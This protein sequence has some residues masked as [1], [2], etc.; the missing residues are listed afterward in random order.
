M[1]TKLL[2]LFVFVY[3]YSYT[4]SYIP[5]LEEDHTWSVD[6]YYDTFGGD[7]YT[8]T[9]QVTVSGAV[10]VNGKTYKQVFNNDGE[11]SCLVREENGIIYQLDMINTTEIIKYD[12]TLEVG[13]TF[14]FTI[15][16]FCTFSDFSLFG[17]I[18]V[19]EVTT[20]FIAG[21]NRKVIEFDYLRFT[22][23]NE[24]WIEGIGSISGFDSIGEATDY[25]NGTSLVC[26]DIAGTNYFFNGA[27]SCDNT[28]LGIDDLSQ[29]QIILYPNPVTSTS[30]LQFSSEGIVDA[31]KIYDISGKLVKEEKVSKDY[32]RIDAMQYRSGLYFYQVFSENELL[33]T[34]KFIIK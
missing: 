30:I 2:V 27:T 5:M 18:E 4:Q 21:E 29:V 8:I 3:C 31:L 12:F 6:V 16:E 22:Q 26:F 34:E 19:V 28:T 7:V 32:V 17:P 10:V 13:D 20:A 14:D 15:S 11:T 24:Q 33:K 1:K 9:E 25:T 23:E